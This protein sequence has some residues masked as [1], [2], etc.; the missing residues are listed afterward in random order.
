MKT[1]YLFD[2]RAKQGHKTRLAPYTVQ[3]WA[4]SLAGAKKQAQKLNDE[5]IGFEIWRITESETGETELL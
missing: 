3:H 2:V 5:L 1:G 4:Y